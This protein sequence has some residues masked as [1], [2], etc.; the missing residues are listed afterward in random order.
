MTVN[1]FAGDDMIFPDTAVDTSAFLNVQGQNVEFNGISST[2][3]AMDANFQPVP[4]GGTIVNQSLEQSLGTITNWASP[5]SKLYRWTRTGN[6]IDFWWF[7]TSSGGSASSSSTNFGFD[8]P[9]EVPSPINNL[10][11]DF[12]GAT[13]Q[14]GISDA[15]TVGGGQSSKTLSSRSG[16]TY[17]I[18]TFLSAANVQTYWGGHATWMI[19]P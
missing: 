11:N 7:I 1:A 17:S 15:P 16:S 12:D 10:S 19:N 9:S 2:R 5:G 4:V 13:G 8:I 14:I 6:K 3:W 18:T